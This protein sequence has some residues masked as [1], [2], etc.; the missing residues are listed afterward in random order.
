MI[1]RVSAVPW[2]NVITAVS[3]VTA[4]LGAVA[5]TGRYNDRARRKEQR[6]ADYAR[7]VQAAWDLL[8][9]HRQV[10][11]M[12]TRST[13]D[14]ARAQE[15]KSRTAVLL[16]ELHR[17]VAVAEMAG[18]RAAREGAKRLSQKSRQGVSNALVNDG[19]DNWFVFGMPEIG[20]EF[21]K[22]IQSFIDVARSEITPRPFSPFTQSPPP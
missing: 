6:Q 19:A 15:V 5:L 12:A 8:D 7:L 2:S 13:I 14:D 9:Y 16:G 11:E 1:G 22:E 17:A 21:E 3:S 20:V 4:A 18:S 10:V